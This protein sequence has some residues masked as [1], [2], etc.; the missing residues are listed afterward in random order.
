MKWFSKKREEYKVDKVEEKTDTEGLLKES[1]D[2]EKEKRVKELTKK[3]ESVYTR[4]DA[5][6]NLCQYL[7]AEKTVDFLIESLYD[8]NPKIRKRAAWAFA[9]MMFSSIVEKNIVRDKGVVEHLIKALLHDEDSSVST[10]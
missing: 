5:V 2:V 7:G 8:D 10:S 4:E 3:L 9:S 1:E 6:R